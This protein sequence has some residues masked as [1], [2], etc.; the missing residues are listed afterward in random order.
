[1]YVVRRLLLFVAALAVGVAL[2]AWLFHPNRSAPSLVAITSPPRPDDTWLDRLYNQNP[3]D[4]ADAAGVVEELGAGAVPAIR[5]VLQDPNASRERQKAALKACGIIGPAA[6]PAI[7]DVAARLSQPELT[8]EAAVALS[9]MGAPAVA[10][11]QDAL[12]SDNALVRRE[13]LRSI[14]KLKDRAG[15]DT[16][17]VLPLLVDS[18][19]DPDAGVRAVAATY[20]GIIH[21]GDPLAV[22]ALIKAL[23]DPEPDVRRVSAEALGSFGDAAKPSLPALRKATADVDP[24]VAR[25][26]GVALVKLQTG[27]Q[28]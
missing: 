14:G 23:K 17:A 8:S 20:L 2:G 28:P 6:A 13:S 18:M 24:E 21:E 3:A 11:L 7:P 15:L 19:D 22:P 16:N 12:A 9:F 5:K 27:R 10:P 25:A 4:A 26:A 1:M